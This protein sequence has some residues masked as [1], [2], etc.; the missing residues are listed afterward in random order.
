MKTLEEIFDKA[1]EAGASADDAKAFG[2][3]SKL[4]NPL[5]VDNQLIVDCDIGYRKRHRTGGQ[6]DV[7]CRSLVGIAD[8]GFDRY[9]AP[10]QQPASTIDEFNLI[11]LEQLHQ[12]AVELLYDL[13]LALNHPGDIHAQAID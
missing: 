7:F 4:Q 3:L 9:F 2:N 6:H 1:E 13:A 11:G 8:V 12:A 5:V 10:G